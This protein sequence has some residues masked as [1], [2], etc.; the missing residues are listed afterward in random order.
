MAY[1]PY[2]IFFCSSTSSHVSGAEELEI[3]FPRF[4]C[5]YDFGYDLSSADDGKKFLQEKLELNIK[6]ESIPNGSIY[7]KFTDQSIT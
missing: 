5:S 1:N 3:I 7:N 4:L 2:V 6:Q